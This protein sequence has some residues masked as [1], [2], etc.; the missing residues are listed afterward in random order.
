[1]EC[2]TGG[3]G[4]RL[5]AV[6][7]C[8]ERPGG[9]VLL[10][11]EPGKAGKPG[12]KRGHVQP[13][14]R[15]DHAAGG[16]GQGNGG[17]GLHL[18]RKR[19]RRGRRGVQKVPCG[20]VWTGPEGHRPVCHSR[21][22]RGLYPAD[23]RRVQQHLRVVPGTGGEEKA[24]R[25][26]HGAGGIRLRAH[27]AVRAD[28]AGRGGIRKECAGVGDLGEGAPDPVLRG[29]CA[30]LPFPGHRLPENDGGRHRNQRP[31]KP[32]D[33]CTHERLQHGRHKLCEHRPGNGLQGDRGE[34]GLGTVRAECGLLPLPDGHERGRQR[35]TGGRGNRPGRADG[36]HFLHGRVRSLQPSKGCDRAG[37]NE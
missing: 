12:R 24:G 28:A 19:R 25:G 36:R 37:R 32:A 23:G 10:R 3:G 16:H 8:P 18:Q 21:R 29:N 1:M 33:L 13:L 17:N 4:G 14:Q 35:G 11:R 5:R 2:E 31:F 15:G 26:A 20:Q 34:H 30:C 22:R 6:Q 9:T 7:H 27:G